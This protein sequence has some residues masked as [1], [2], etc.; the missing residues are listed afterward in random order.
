LRII[1]ELD[2]ARIDEMTRAAA[3]NNSPILM[4]AA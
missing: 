3:N 1:H 4:L 2:R